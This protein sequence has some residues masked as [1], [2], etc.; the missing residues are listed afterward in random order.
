MPSAEGSLKWWPLGDRLD[1]VAPPVAERAAH[2]PEAQVASI[3]PALAD[4]AAFCEA[5]DVAPENSANCVVVV[6]RRGGEAHYAAVMVLATMRADVNGVI[7]R[8]LDVRKCSFAPMHEAVALTRMEFGG[9]TPIGLPAE[10]P[11]LVDESVAAA[12]DVVVGSGLRRSKLLIP[13][14]ALV[15][16]HGSRRLTLAT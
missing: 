13:A 12:G 6:G 11:I 7:R 8:H 15:D 10:W 9:I 5:Y 16:L 3:D 1:L 14:R 4:T 2:Y